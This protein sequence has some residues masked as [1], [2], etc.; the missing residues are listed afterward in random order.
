MSGIDYTD[1]SS[2]WLPNVLTACSG[3]A[4]TIKL[5]L[6]LGLSTEQIAGFLHC[7]LKNKE[8]ICA[9][10]MPLYQTK[11]ADIEKQ[12]L[13]LNQIKLNL[14]QRMAAILQEQEQSDSGQ[15][16]QIP[17]YRL[18]VPALKMM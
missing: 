10:V 8:A 4:G 16:R 14:E 3:N 15:R 18:S 9:E 2:Q 6:N 12:L 5:Y 7:V 11:L 17:G 1:S 13:Q